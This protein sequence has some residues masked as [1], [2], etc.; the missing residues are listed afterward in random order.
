MSTF[1]LTA[2]GP[3]SLAPSLAFLEG[4]T[5]ASYQPG[6]DPAL[7]LAFPI[8]GSWQ[9]VGVRVREH[10]GGVRGE[11]L[12]PQPSEKKLT[13]AV[14]AQVARILSLDVDGSGF[15]DVGRRDKVVAG[16]QQRYPGLRPVCFYSPYEAAA[17]AIIGHRIRIRQAAAIKTRMAEQLGEPVSFGDDTVHAFPAPQRLAELQAFPGLSGR[18]PEWLR[19]LAHGALEGRLDAAR[20]RALPAEQALATLK[21]LPGIG[22]FSA[23]LVLL[24]GAGDPDRV[25]HHEP[26]LAR[27]VAVAYGLPATPSDDELEQLSENWRP[28]RTWV[29]LLLR[30]H[31]EDVTGEISG[32]GPHAGR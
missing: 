11:V 1:T 3:F 20:L 16:L 4:F 31:L 18:K 30:A 26:R 17:W 15:P 8:E 24:R 29:C 12:S 25:P 28:Y 9:T 5:P 10:A 13:E 19:A 23:E 7:K 22:D 21:E 27:A 32:T 2:K 6:S 14:R